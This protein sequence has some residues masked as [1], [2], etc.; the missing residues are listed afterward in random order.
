MSVVVGLLFALGIFAGARGLFRLM[1]GQGVV[2]DSAVAF[3]RTLFGGAAISF[4]AAMFD[5]I[6]RGEGNVRVPAIWSSVSLGLQVLVTP[7]FMFVA[8]WGLEGAALAMLTC[9]L[10]AMIPRARHVFGGRGVIRPRPW[11]RR[12]AVEAIVEI[13]RVGIP[14]S[15]STTTNYV[16]M[17]VLTGVVARLGE[18]DLAAYGLGVRLDFLLISF[19]YGFSAAVLT[20]VGLATGAGRTERAATYVVRA[21]TVI[22]TLLAVPGAILCWRPSLWLGLFTDDAHIHAVGAEYFRYIGP[23]YPFVGISMVIAFA[24]QGLGRATAPLLLAVVRVIAVLTIAI[25][26]TQ[27]LG[28]EERAVF[29]TIAASNVCSAAAMATLFLRAQKALRQ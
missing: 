24:F 18:G 20:L 14:A 1:G 2:L 5:S 3:A 21:G 4:T 28:L 23:S 11:P 13:L 8:G 25:V 22:V 15:L 19:A 16:G 9:Q 27:W 17:M 29:I 26:C 6:M 10:L 7:L 12:P